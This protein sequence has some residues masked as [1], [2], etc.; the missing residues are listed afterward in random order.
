MMNLVNPAAPPMRAQLR[1]LPTLASAI[2]A[3]NAAR[4]KSKLFAYNMCI[5]FNLQLQAADRAV[6]PARALMAAR[7]SCLGC[8]GAAA[9]NGDPRLGAEVWPR[10]NWRID[11]PTL[12][13]PA[14]PNI[15]PSFLAIKAHPVPISSL[16]P[17]QRGA[18]RK[19]PRPPVT[20]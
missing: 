18:A 19:A 16:A 4:Q 10:A 20:G 7:R 14:T 11:D 13:P 12:P 5:I 8:G 9:S 6:L 3:S 17:G 15:E 2:P 1:G